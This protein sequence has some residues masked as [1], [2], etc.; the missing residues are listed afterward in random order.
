MRRTRGL[1][2]N[3]VRRDRAGGKRVKVKRRTEERVQNLEARGRLRPARP[4]AHLKVGVRV[5]GVEA[6]EDG[7]VQDHGPGGGRHA[8]VEHEVARSER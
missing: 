3:M 6:C 4:L 8:V 1:V 5:A 2:A 7:A